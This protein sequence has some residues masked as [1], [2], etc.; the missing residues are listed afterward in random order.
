MVIPQ[1]SKLKPGVRFPCTAFLSVIKF[2]SCS[3]FCWVVTFGLSKTLLKREN[4]RVLVTALESLVFLLDHVV[5]HSIVH[6]TYTILIS[7]GFKRC[8]L[9][10]FDVSTSPKGFSFSLLFFT[11]TVYFETF[12]KPS[13]KKTDYSR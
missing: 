10:A 8:G 11:H 9:E 2:L 1:S 13:F 4:I 6:D 12:S 7:S 3:R 5:V